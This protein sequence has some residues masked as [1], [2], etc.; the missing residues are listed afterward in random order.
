MG[1][2][3]RKISRT[4][5][6]D[7]RLCTDGTNRRSHVEDQTIT[8]KFLTHSSSCLVCLGDLICTWQV[9]KILL[10]LLF[11]CRSLYSLHRGWAAME[12]T[13]DT[14]FRCL[15]F[16]AIIGFVYS[17]ASFGGSSWPWGFILPMMPS[18]DASTKTTPIEMN[19]NMDP[20]YT[21]NHGNGLGWY[22]GILMSTAVGIASRGG[23]AMGTT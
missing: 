16:S 12:G 13:V 17:W 9:W 20:D 19:N 22:L 1:Y 5:Y 8:S 11:A 23:R 4:S 10:I 21:M 3:T 7:D 6:L 18:V 2:P 15:I 14:S